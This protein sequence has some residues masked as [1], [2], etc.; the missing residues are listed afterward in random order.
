VAGEVK[1]LAREATQ[2]MVEVSGYLDRMGSATQQSARGVGGVVGAL[3]EIGGATASVASAVHQQHTAVGELDKRTLAV[4]EASARM[5]ERAH[6]LH[7]TMVQARGAMEELARVT[8]GLASEARVLDD[9]S[10]HFAREL[11]IVSS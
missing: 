9:A 2:S 4:R 5:A 7:E 10:R 1:E 3:D 11:A 8:M 6:S